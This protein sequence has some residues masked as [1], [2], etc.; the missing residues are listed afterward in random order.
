MPTGGTAPGKRSFATAINAKGTAKEIRKQACSAV[1][2]GQITVNSPTLTFTL[3]VV[4]DHRDTAVTCQARYL[5]EK[6]IV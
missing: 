3:L 5:D 4:V 6:Y 2:E 1:K